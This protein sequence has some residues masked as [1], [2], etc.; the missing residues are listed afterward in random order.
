MAKNSSKSQFECS[1]CGRVTAKWVGKC[2][3]CGEWNT[4]EE[5]VVHAESARK[6][7][8]IIDRVR[9]G[10]ESFGFERA[11]EAL[12]VEGAG[13]SGLGSG[14]VGRLGTASQS[15]PLGLPRSGGEGSHGA[16]ELNSI[17]SDGV[18]HMATGLDELDR[19]LGGGFVAGSTT[20]LAGDPGIG[21]ST[22]L[23]QA[24]SAIAES[25]KTVLYATGE[26]ALEQIRIRASRLGVKGDRVFMAGTGDAMAIAEL[27]AELHPTVTIVDSIQTATHPD[28]DSPAGTVS[29]IREC[30]AFLSEIA[31]ASHTAL[32][33][34]GHVTK[35]GNIAGPRVLEHQVDAVLQMGGDTGGMLRMLHGVKNRFGPTDEI[36]VFE[37]REEGLAGISDPSHVF[38]QQR[39]KA[40]SGSCVALVV[41]GTRSL[42]VEVQALATASS[43]ASPRRVANGVEMSRVHLITAVLAKHMRLPVSN[44]DLV[45]SVTGGLDIKEPAADLAIALA[46]AS[47]MMDRPVNETVAVAGEIGLSGELRSIPRADRRAAEAGRLGFESCMIPD[48][49]GDTGKAGSVKVVRPTNIAEAVRFALQPVDAGG[50]SG[51]GSGTEVRS[52][53]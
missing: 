42:A 24:A 38:I 33:L 2:S 34:S 43:L 20:L 49:A 28:L 46:I 1:G 7:P 50:S 22:L 27:V 12:G 21:K 25:G 10:A 51:S 48:A 4:V 15:P 8:G 14:V 18:A 13:V 6:A 32:M 30:A 53:M 11:D 45:I 5:K 35:D 40:V 39:A 16:V 19:V 52:S 23:L 41:E 3:G 47:S 29:Q 17:S 37:M 44:H 9:Q 31:R 36:G 26:E